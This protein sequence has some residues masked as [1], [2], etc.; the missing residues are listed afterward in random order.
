MGHGTSGRQFTTKA[1]LAALVCCLSLCVLA[2]SAHA[3]LPYEEV[4]VFAGSKTPLTPEQIEANEEIQ[5]GGVNGMAINR[6]GAGGVPKGTVYAV[7]GREGTLRIARYDPVAE[8]KAGEPWLKFAVAWQVNSEEGPYERCGPL[9]IAEGK[10]G[11]CKARIEQAGQGTG[12]A[13]DQATGYVFVYNGDAQVGLQ[14]VTV[15]T[16]DGAAVVTRFAEKAPNE[17]KTASTPGKFHGTALQG[18]IVVNEAGEAYVFDLNSVFAAHDN[19]YH[20]LM[21]FRPEKAGD[22]SKYEYA[23][24]IAAGFIFENNYPTRPV[25]DDAGRLYVADEEHIER[26]PAQEPEPYPA[27]HPAPACSFKF[28][29]A[30][31]TAMTVDP[32]TGEPFFF[33]YKQEKEFTHKV[34]H[35]LGPCEEGKF[36]ETARYEV[37][38]ERGDLTALALDPERRLEA[39]RPAGVLYGAA[40]NSVSSTIGIGEPGQGALGYVFARPKAQPVPAKVGEEWVAGASATTARLRAKINP[41]GFATSYR[42]QYLTE[43]EYEEAGESFSGAHEAPAG[44]AGIG[45]GRTTL[46]VGAIAQGLSPDTAYRWRVLAESKCDPAEEAKVCA[47]PGQAKSFH[48]FALEAPGLADNRAWEL[49][50]PAQKGGGQVLPADPNTS[51]CDVDHGGIECKPGASYNHFPMQSTPGGDAIAYEGTPF[52]SD[53]AVI[54]NEYLAKRDPQSGWQSTNLTPPLLESRGGGGYLAFDPALESALLEQLGTALSPEALEGHPDLYAQASADPFSLAPLLLAGQV[55]PHCP[56]GNVSDRLRLTYAGASNDLSRVF[57]AAND[58]LTPEAVGACG[59]ANLY[60][61]SAA[62]LRAVNLLP[63]ATKTSPG[64]A[65]GSGTLLKSG[66]SNSPSIVVTNAISDDGARAFFSGKTG[67]VYVRIGASKT[68]EIPDHVGKFLAAA[69]DGSRVLLSNGRIYDLETKAT[70]DLSAG[71]GGFEGLVGQSED[72]THVYFV[73]SAVLSGEEANSEGQKAQAGKANLYSW[74]GGTTRF[75][76]TLAGGDTRVNAGFGLGLL[77]DTEAAPALRSAQAS[78]N[79]RWLAFGSTVSLSGYENAGPCER[80]GAFAEAPCPEAFLYD[81]A[82]GELICASCNPS[83]ARPLGWSILRLLVLGVPGSRPQQ[84]YLTDSGRLYFDSRDSLALADTNEGVEDVY[85]YEPDGVGTCKREEG[86]INL[87]SAGTGSEDSNLVTVDETGANVFFTTRDRLVLKDK[88]ELVDLY[89]ARE[90]GGIPAETETGRGECSGEACQPPVVVPE[91]PTPGSSSF[92]GAGNVVE[93][94]TVTR[95][96]CAK[97]KVK[98]RGKCVRRHRHHRRAARHQRRAHR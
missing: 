1:T 35:Q 58:A 15:Y 57:F 23:G 81:S 72:L 53:G 95:K 31:I 87:I 93:Q 33:S 39:S 60:E 4:G 96:P 82:S 71:K 12:V 45:A 61:S 24:E 90:G 98:R 86:C 30:G 64:A 78:P 41:E 68:T 6:T 25:F 65:F 75:V 11:A 13:V 9:V 59:E 32:T 49:V 44:G 7:V 52:S 43:D 88:D 47:V 38:P 51:S 69:K 5:L 54:E 16:P 10:G 14:A 36:K 91:D 29:K 77:T 97:G 66:N 84:P 62:G 18:G 56:Q 3:G 63:G 20:R 46:E 79:G 21:V 80:R 2:A 19:F 28:A 55:A 67:Q 85:Q 74:S 48:T 42:F 40:P 92:E 22:Y 89:D 17:M 83:G 27:A 94:P 34:I 50:S 26:L 76:A 73:D 8:P 37:T 70:T